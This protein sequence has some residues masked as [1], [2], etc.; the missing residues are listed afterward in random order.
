LCSTTRI[1]ALS[2]RPPPPPS[3]S[4]SAKI[5]YTR[6]KSRNI[7]TRS[8]NER[9]SVCISP[10]RLTQSA[11]HERPIYSI[12]FPGPGMSERSLE[13]LEARLLLSHRC[14]YACV[15]LTLPAVPANVF[16]RVC[17]LFALSIWPQHEVSCKAATA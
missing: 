2:E 7:A 1:I 17:C 14:E 16:M 12:D 13:A 4:G 11:Q 10:K 9:H 6:M 3:Y 5:C 15:G 8:Y